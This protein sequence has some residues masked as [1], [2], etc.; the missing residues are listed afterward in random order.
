MFKPD[1]DGVFKDSEY[2][3]QYTMA[4]GDSAL[5][6]VSIVDVSGNAYVSIN[7]AAW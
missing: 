1:I 2:V 4:N 6:F 7:W 5:P 3:E